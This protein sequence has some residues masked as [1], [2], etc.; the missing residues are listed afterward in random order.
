MGHFI[1]LYR[2]DITTYIG[3]LLLLLTKHHKLGGL[4]NTNVLSYWSESQK[5]EMGLTGL[6]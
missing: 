6:K 1:F 5:S 3:F 4:N 2:N